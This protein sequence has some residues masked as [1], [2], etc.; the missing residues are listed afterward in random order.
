MKMRIQSRKRSEDGLGLV[1]VLV[2]C[3]LLG[4]LLASHMIWAKN[5]SFITRRSMAWNAALPM[6]E[7]GV[8]EALS[9]LKFH[10]TSMD[11]DGWKFEGNTYRKTRV[12]TTNGSYFTVQ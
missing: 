11:S 8:E 6:A 9:Q 10:P 4:V 1:V 12:L 5:H 7:A 2:L 3:G